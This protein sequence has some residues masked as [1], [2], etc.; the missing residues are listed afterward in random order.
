M[1][2]IFQ[3][4]SICFPIFLT[5]V[6]NRA[7]MSVVKY[8]ISQDSQELSMQTKVLNPIYSYFIMKIDILYNVVPTYDALSVNSVY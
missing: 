3:V 2:T 4:H 6:S 7:H 1:Q 5:K 8:V